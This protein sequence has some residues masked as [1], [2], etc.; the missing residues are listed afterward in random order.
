MVRGFRVVHRSGGL[1]GSSRRVA[2]LAALALAGAALVGIGSPT[3]AAA[4]ASTAITFAT[5]MVM[6]PN[7]TVGEPTI[8]HS[9][10]ADGTVYASGPWGTGT[11]RSIWDASADGGE[12]FRLVGQ[13]APQSG[14][15]A[16]RLRPA[17][18]RRVRSAADR[19]HQHR[20]G[21]FA[22]PAHVHGVQQPADHAGQPG[23]LGEEHRW[24]ELH[25]G[26]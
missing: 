2:T 3:G 26:Q 5:P 19:G 25:P 9:P 1:H 12:T 21:S 24:P 6:D 7:H 20:A 4:K 16:G 15:V 23:V 11:Q 14:E 17:M 13:C 8:V 22:R 10:A 18:A